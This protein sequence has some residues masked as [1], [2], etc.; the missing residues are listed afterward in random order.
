MKQ[1]FLLIIFL[2]MQS[3]TSLTAQEKSKPLDIL[4]SNVVFSNNT[5]ANRTIQSS[6]TAPSV[7]NATVSATP[8]V[9]TPKAYQYKLQQ[10][11]PNP[12]N[13]V[14]TISFSIAQR[15]EVVITVYDILGR[16]VKTLLNEVKPAGNYQVR[17]DASQ[18]A[19]GIYFYRMMA[20]KNY[21]DIKKM[22]V[23][24]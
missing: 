20:G 15:S 1:L 11:Y 10:N 4:S 24:K 21:N 13:P 19:S 18:L 9:E 14:T 17:F 3:L 8:K 22:I 12:F 2:A 23:L 7:T 6:N 5:E 16:R